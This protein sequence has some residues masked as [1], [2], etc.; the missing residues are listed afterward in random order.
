MFLA[1]S[2]PIVV[3]SIADGSFG[4]WMLDSYHTLALLM[5]GAGAIHPIWN[6]MR[7]WALA[8]LSAR[9]WRTTAL[10]ALALTAILAGA[11]TM[12]AL[13]K[14][15]FVHVVEVTPEGQVMSIRAADGAW[16]PNAAQTAYHL[17]RFVRLVRS[18]PT[19]GVVLRDNWLEAYKLL[20]PGAAAHLTDMARRR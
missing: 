3:I 20:T 4:S 13:Q 18:L 15:T 7:A 14:R 1:R 6:G 8:I 9:S 12:V 10:G 17:G 2:S 16:K 19:D 5:P 11:L